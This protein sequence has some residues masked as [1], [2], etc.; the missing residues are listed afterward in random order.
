MPDLLP[1]DFGTE[2]LQPPVLIL[3]EQAEHLAKR[4]GGLVLGKVATQKLNDGGFGHR[5]ILEVPALDDY[6]FTL[7]TVI[8]PLWMY[9][10]TFRPE[11]PG[12][13]GETRVESPAGFED[14]LRMVFAHPEVG[15]VITALK[16]QAMA[17]VPTAAKT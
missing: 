7:F 5:F 16:A 15:K 3:R 17:A 4:T 14:T 10:L 2:T 9:P 1:D 12:W 8:H 6:A 13:M 11:L